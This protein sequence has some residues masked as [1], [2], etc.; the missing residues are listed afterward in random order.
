MQPMDNK[1]RPKVHVGSY[2]P[3]RMDEWTSLDIE[4]VTT[5]PTKPEDDG[6]TGLSTDAATL[7]SEFEG[8]PTHLDEVK[9]RHLEVLVTAGMLPESGLADVHPERALSWV[10]NSINGRLNP[11]GL[12]IPLLGSSLE[13][14]QLKTK[15]TDE[16]TVVMLTVEDGEHP[17]LV[18]ELP[19][20][21]G[22]ASTLEATFHQGRLHLRW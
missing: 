4:T 17:E 11:D 1:A 14:V 7:Q 16:A 19:L 10:V 12:T 20:P 5:E 9:Q 22:A 21:L 15:V 6:L 8:R 13:N 3:S 2:A 18:R